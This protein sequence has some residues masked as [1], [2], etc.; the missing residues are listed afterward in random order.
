M[1][2]EGRMKIL[3]FKIGGEYDYNVA[4]ETES[5]KQKIQTN[6]SPTGDL[7]A[8]V[9]NVVNASI[10]YFRFESISAKFKSVTF[11]YPESGPTNFQ[12][13]FYIKTKENVFVEHLLKTEKLRLVQE[14]TESTDESFLI[15]IEEQNDLIKEIFAFREEI[16]LYAQGARAQN[17][18][19]FEN[20]EETD[21]DNNL[22]DSDEFDINEGGN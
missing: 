2:Q 6:D 5:E 17:E 12:L 3:Q 9:S 1:E 19:P 18:L 8:A 16:E 14:E 20:G 21:S 11:S 15:R 13:E 4:Y 10:K 7:L 22:F